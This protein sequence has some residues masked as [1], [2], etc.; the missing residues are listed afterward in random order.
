MATKNTKMV[1]AKA[2]K[3]RKSVRKVATTP[4]SL[5]QLLVNS[6]QKSVR[7]TLKDHYYMDDLYMDD[8]VDTVMNDLLY[9]DKV[10]DGRITALVKEE[11]EHLLAEPMAIRTALVQRLTRKL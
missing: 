3:G 5:D 11:L 4:L 7:E 10:L 8:L 9:H 2:S 1:K 6:V